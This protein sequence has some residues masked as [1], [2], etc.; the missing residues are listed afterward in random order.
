[1]K[2][3]TKGFTAVEG[4]LIFLVLAIIGG[5]GWFVMKSRDTA[6]KSL[7]NANNSKTATTAP[8]KAKPKVENYYDCWDVKGTT[9][10]SD[11]NY[12]CIYKGKTY[13]LPSVYSTD[14]IRGYDKLPKDARPLAEQLAK[15]L[16]DCNIDY[17]KRLP[18]ELRI[19]SVAK[20][21]Y[22]L[23][24]L[25]CDGGRG[26]LLYKD[27][28]GKW[29]EVNLGQDNINCEMVEKYK[30]PASLFTDSGEKALCL[31]PDGSDKPIKY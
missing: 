18:S 25:S 26:G 28:M 17:G 3:N 1:M 15:K 12:D 29:T 13:K 14:M 10:G 31:M 2:L 5:A 6:N 16:F 8:K 24:S 27:D 21:R 4:L 9:E 19:N 30:I 20:E 11:K 7:D 22:A 23:I